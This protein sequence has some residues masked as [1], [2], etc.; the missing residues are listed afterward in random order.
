MAWPKGTIQYY[1]KKVATGKQL[2]KDLTEEEAYQFL[3]MILEGKTS[4]AQN[5]AFFAAMR[6]KGETA[7]EIAGF[8][9]AV[10]DS[11][12][13][14]SPKVPFLVDLGY[15]YD[16]KLRTQILIIGACLV[17]A[18][19]GVSV[20][21]HGARNVPPKRGRSP[22]ELLEQLGIPVDLSPQESEEFLKETGI[23]Y[24]SC[25]KFSPPLANFL[26]IPAE[27]SIRSPLSAVHKLV[28]PAQASVTV[29]GIT[30]PPYFETMSA[31]MVR[32]NVP[33]GWVVKGIEGTM[34]LSLSHSTEMVSVRGNS[35]EKSRIDPR[36]YGLPNIMDSEF[37]QRSL[38]ENTEV[39]LKAL[40]GKET[41]FKESFIW[42][43]AFLI[44]ASGKS[45][46]IEAALSLARG[47]LESGEAFQVLERARRLVLKD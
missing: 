22:E 34:E 36:A 35:I 25:R 5:G 13:R 28:N 24:L 46:S 31:A 33:R 17:A 4:P 41:F 44:F 6:M 10:Q 16:G 42:N 15:P 37:T 9:K 40:E 18:A 30:H 2:S 21:L 3:K 45:D 29:L 39:T 32:L 8:T 7:E 23:G 19:G 26:E 1:I 38:E 14:I 27:I 43:G 12:K 11:S 20:M 47:A